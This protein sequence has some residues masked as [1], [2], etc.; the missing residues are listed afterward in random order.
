MC[1][2]VSGAGICSSVGTN[3]ITTLNYRSISSN[4]K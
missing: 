2:C 1:V 3:E 4:L